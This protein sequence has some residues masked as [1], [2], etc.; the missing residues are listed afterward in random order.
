MPL[1]NARLIEKNIKNPKPLPTEHEAV[2]TAW[3][4][5]LTKGIYDSETKNDGQFIQRILV[6]VLGYSESAHGSTWTV[7]KNQPVGKGNVDVA[8]GEFSAESTTIIAPFELKGAKTKDLDAIMPGR[9]KSPIQQAWEYAMDAKGAKWVLV[10]N[11]REI[12]LYAVGYGRKDYEH[13]DLTT[14]AQPENYAR[15]ML[16]LSANNLLGEQTLNLLK[17]SEKAGKEIT[18][19]LYADYRALRENVIRTLKQDNSPVPELEIISYA[20]TIL[21]RVLFIAFSEDRGL[22]PEHTLEKAFTHQDPYNPKPVWENFKGLFRSIDKGNAQL[23]IPAYNGGLFRQN[24]I[25]DALVVS[26]ALCEGFKKL[27]EYDFNTEVSVTVLGHIFEQ[28]ITDL[29]ALQ[30][31]ATGEEIEIKQGATTGKR[32]REGVVYTPDSLTRFIVEETLG[33][34]LKTVFEETISK[35]ITKASAGNLKAGDA[36]VSWKNN[37]AELN[38]W[39]EYQDRL[40]NLRVVDPA[41]GSGAF[42]VAAFDFLHAEYTR[43]NDRLTTLK[44]GMADLFDLDKEILNQ[45]LYGVD[46]N[47]ESIEITKLSLWLKTA[48]R[49]KVLNSLDH[50]LRVGNS[51]IADKAYA[52]RAFDWKQAFPEVFE[53]GGFDVVLGNPP[54]V[55]QERFSECKP[56][57]QSHYACY[58]GV[59]DLYA[60]FYELGLNLLRDGGRLGYISSGTFFKTSSG[61]P[62]RQH[63]LAHAKFQ[64]IVDFGDLQVFEG[65]T[66]YPVIT[67]MEKAVADKKH[68]L[69][70]LSLTQLPELDLSSEFATSSKAMLQNQLTIEG[71]NLGDVDVASLRA[72]IFKG[73]TPLKVAYSSPYRGILTGY[74]E[75][76]VIDRATRDKLIAENANAAEL[77]KPF[78]EG[79]DIKPWR[80]ESRDLYLIFTRRGTDLE[81][82]PSIKKHLESFRTRLEPKPKDW[83]PTPEVKEWGGRKAGSYKWFE[84]QDSVDYHAEFE[85]PKITYGHFS[86]TALFSLDTSGF[87]SNDKSYIIPDA[88]WYLLGLLN[89]KLQWFIIKSLC[90]YV[91]GGFYEV[92]SQYIENLPIASPNKSQKEAIGSLAEQCQKAAEELY[93]LSTK[94]LNLLKT[95][96]KL[97]KP[98]TKLEQWHSLD[99]AGFLDELKKKK[100]V[101]TLT[102]KSEWMDYFEKQKTTAQSLKQT[103]TKLEQ[104][105]NQQVYAL[106]ALTPEEIQIIEEAVV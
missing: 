13:F 52:P 26:D 53:A 101:P 83:E 48:K 85:K 98:S 38:F 97:E 67:V 30:A 24:D 88:D 75:A 86:P 99:F 73:K 39:K 43:V 105:L 9:N 46:I 55:R 19:R 103:I 84:I 1:F 71:W 47:P 64:R 102:Q 69:R 31:Q 49:G 54:Y 80:V 58:H 25:P 36:L 60:F 45:N 96:F 61:Q 95:D 20:Q 5:N 57:L 51:V 22:L 44:G 106:Y 17:E 100:I 2:L 89:S 15:F 62:L 14:L 37:K 78:L 27:G 8:L 23:N 59:A 35:H 76:F 65:V 33:G 34:Y 16:L 82:Y 90:P 29:E 6:D 3:A 70:F 42:L 87:Y 81:A 11:Y 104:E 91:R 56:Y 94:F 63:L 32:K 92:R 4:E 40:R 68:D 41:C 18:N 12:R 79:K 93:A 10:S 21:D 50:T 74:N 72:K 28:S 66:T 77:I 7:Q